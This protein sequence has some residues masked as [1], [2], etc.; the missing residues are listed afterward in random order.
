MDNDKSI[1]TLTRSKLRPFRYHPYKVKEDEDMANLVNSIKEEGVISPIIVRKVGKDNYE[2]LSGH[3]RFKACQILDIKG[4]PVIV[5]DIQMPEA[6]IY[7]VD[8]NL[9][10]ENLL[11]SEKAFAYKLKIDAMRRQGKITEDLDFCQVGKKYKTEAVKEI[12]N[13][14]G[15]SFRQIYRYIRLTNLNEGLLEYLDQGRIAFNPAVELSYL[16]KRQQD[17]LLE[18][19]NN[20]DVTPSFSQSQYL[21][22]LAKEGKYIEDAVY[23]VL[24]EL[25]PNQKENLKIS[26]DE[27]RDYFER[28]TTPNE[29]IKIIKK[30]LA[31]YYLE[32]NSKKEEN[33]LKI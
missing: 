21:R 30:S 4:I 5:K 1:K 29:M 23:D 16:S 18:A 33:D 3:R 2:I 12:A 32:Q 24:D 27:L 26:L 10:R 15:T 25:K 22:E 6:A 19:I 17:I 14:E 7:V 31:K 28:G 20:L 9:Q 8:S 13:K 11:P